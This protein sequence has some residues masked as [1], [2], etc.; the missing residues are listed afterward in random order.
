MVADARPDLVKGMIAIEVGIPFYK[1]EF[2][3]A[4]QWYEVGEL[5]KPWGLTNEPLTYSPQPASPKDIK[6]VQQDKPDRPDLVKCWLQ[7]EPA[8]QLPNL[9][10]V[11]IMLLTAEAYDHASTDHC[12]VKYFEQ[13][14]VH[15]TWIYLPDLGIRGNAHDMMM[16]KN[17]LEVAEV[18]HGWITKTAIGGA[19]KTQ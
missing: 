16:E 18:L 13:V 9:Q 2:I 6:L 10:K 5:S 3:G 12:F 1:P 14:G 15:P 8:R 11:P 7:Q 4:P 17:N 19:S